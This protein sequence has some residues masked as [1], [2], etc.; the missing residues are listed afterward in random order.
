MAIIISF[1]KPR[2][3]KTSGEHVDE[4]DVVDKVQSIFSKKN[5]ALIVLG[6]GIGVIC[7]QASDINSLKRTIDILTEVVR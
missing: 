4:A 3:A 6:V 1:G 7:K 5:V 2:Q